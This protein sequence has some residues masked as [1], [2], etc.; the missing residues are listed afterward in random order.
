MATLGTNTQ[1]SY[2]DRS[3]Q[4]ASW[5][6]GSDGAFYMNPLADAYD[7][8]G[9]LTIYPWPE[10]SGYWGNP[11]QNTLAEDSD[12]SYKVISNIYFD[13]DI[14][15]VEGLSYRLNTGFEYTG[16]RRGT[17]WGRNTKIGLDNGGVAEVRNDLRTNVLLENIVNYKR[18]IGK[19]NIF[20]TGLYSFQEYIRDDHDLDSSQFP[21]DVLTWYQAN[22]AALVEPSYT[23]EK[24]T[25]ISTMLRLN[26]GFDSK[27]MVTLTGR[28]DGFSGF[29]KDDKYGNFYSGALAW[30][31]HNESFMEDSD[32][33]TLKLRLSYGRNGN[34]AVGAYETLSRLSERSYVNGS[35]SAAGYIPSQLGNDSLGWESTA[36]FNIG[37]DYGFMDNKIRGSIEAYSSRTEDLLL[38]RVV[39]PIHGLTSITENIGET[40]NQGIELGIFANAISKDDFNLNIDGTFSY[41]T[42]E[43]VDLR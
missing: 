16:T 30:N 17:Y 33:S 32:F 43:I 34:Q 22:V 7:E 27:Y 2:A 31:L 26:Y 5:S 19:H 6:G 23:Y 3:G 1:L 39:S 24:T 37:I 38:D 21:N 25:V 14:P 29:G 28:R 8:F 4:H 18:E 9:E 10:E 15:G 41:N 13:V 36:S 40:K 12:K 35:T 11:L 20:V 42:N